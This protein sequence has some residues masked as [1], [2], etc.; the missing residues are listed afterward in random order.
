MS[1][2]I[3]H[4]HA[5]IHEHKMILQAGIIAK[6][7]NAYIHTY[8]DIHTYILGCQLTSTPV[9][10]FFSMKLLVNSPVD[11]RAIMTPKLLHRITVYM[12]VYMYM[13]IVCA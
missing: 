12:Y 11:L 10:K 9:M 7:Y 8:L 2:Y 13:Y 4:I 1:V 6:V 5:Y 3:I